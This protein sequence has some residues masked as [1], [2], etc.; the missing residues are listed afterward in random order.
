MGSDKKGKGDGGK[1]WMEQS[2]TYFFG[3][4]ALL[5]TTPS[6]LDRDC[7]HEKRNQKGQI[8]LSAREWSRG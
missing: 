3:C 4:L 7:S 6:L 5:F 8:R 1:K 2:G